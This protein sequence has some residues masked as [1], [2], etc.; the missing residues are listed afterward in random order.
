MLQ[1]VTAQH[2]TRLACLYVRQSSLQQVMEKTEST[3]EGSFLLLLSS[4]V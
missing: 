1:R 3:A 4:M 2:L